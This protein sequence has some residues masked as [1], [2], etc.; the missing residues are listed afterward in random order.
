VHDPPPARV[1]RTL[2]TKSPSIVWDQ[3]VSLMYRR[4]ESH[5]FWE[6]IL[7]VL[8]RKTVEGTISP[9]MGRAATEDVTRLHESRCDAFR[10]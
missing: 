6:W 1:K 3:A 2:D 5:R 9:E 8:A 10:K 4:P 7:Y